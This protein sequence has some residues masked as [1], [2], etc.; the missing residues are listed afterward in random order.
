MKVSRLFT[1]PGESVCGRFEYNLKTSVLRNTDGSKVFE[2][3]EVEVPRHWSQ[4]AA[5]ILAQ[6]YFRKA[7]VPQRDVSGEF[8]RDESGNVVMGSENSVKQVVHRLAG[9]WREWGEKHGYFDTPEDGESFYDEMVY[10]LLAQMG[11]PNSPQWFNTGLNYAYGITGPAQGHYHVDPATKKVCESEDAYSR[12]QAHACFI[13]S[14]SD[15]LVNEGGIF[16][17]AIREARV[18]KFGSGSGTNYSNLRSSGEK[19]SGG[20]SSS[21]LMS[22]LKIFDSSAGAIKSGGTTRR[23]A[24]MV[25]IDIDHPD[26][27]QFIE[28]KAREEDKVASLV[29]GSRICSRFLQAIVSEALENGADRNKNPKLQR[30]IENAL[31]RAVPMNYIIRVLALVE[32]GF[33]SLDF[34]EYDTNYESE[35]YQTVGGQNSNNTVRVTN[36]FMKAVENDD[37]WTLKERTTG[38][39]ARA[40]NARDLWQKILMSAWK[41]ADPGLQ[42]DTTINEW[43][44][45]PNSGR[46]NA[47]NPC[48][49]YMF[50]DD[51]ACNLASLNL[52]H[53]LDEESGT[54]KVDEIRHASALWTIALE[55]SVLM[56]HFPSK[57]IARLSYEFR[58]LG[59]GFANLGTVLMVLGIPYDSPKALAL[60]GSIS[61]LITGQAYVTSAELARDLGPFDGYAAN[62]KEMLRVIRNH[63]RAA[64]N[65]S[66]DEY[67][68][69]SVKPRGIDS[70]YCSNELFS[71]VGKVWDEA[72]QKGKKHGFRNAQVSVIAP[73]G[74]IG[75]VMDCDT[76]G[77]EPEFAIV[78]FKKLAGGGYFKIVNQ[79]VHKALGRVGYTPEQIEEIE[80]YCKGSGTL[81]GCPSINRQWLIT[82]GF[83][84]ERIEVLEEQLEAVFDIRFAFNKWILGEDFCESLGFTEAQLNDPDF[85]MLEALGATEEDAEAANDY[86]CGTMTIEGAPHLKLEHLPIFDCASRC[87][88]KGQRFIN[89]MAHV[90]MMSGVQP[91]VSGAISKTVNMPST[92]TVNEISEVYLSGWHHMVKAITVYR[93]GSKLSQPLNISS[94]QDLDEVVMLGN[95]DDLDETK[96]PREVQE[97]II[98]RV[99]HRSER[100]MLPKRRKGYIREAYVGGHKV[101]L[102]TGEY[103][104]GS[105]GEVFIDMYKEGAS[106]K[107]LLNCFAVLASKALQYGMPLEELVESFTFT[108]FEPAGAVQGH[109]AIK[110][111]TSILDYVFRSIG[112]DYLGR[113][114]FVHVKAVDEVAQ[115]GV[116]G[117]E[118]QK[119]Q[120][121]PAEVKPVMAV[122]HAQSEYSHTLKNQIVQAKVQG[123]T[124]EQCENCGSMRVK[125]NGTCKVCED[126]GMTTGCS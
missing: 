73:T 28:W 96:G 1:R 43:H 30:L 115:N 122:H 64:H 75:L 11:A 124:G 65:K 58:T 47:S 27:E 16:D 93:D 44:T 86:I 104:D 61:A 120:E 70:E 72:L 106:F 57:D 101:F 25:I 53:F 109:N 95:E 105:L 52:I 29:V 66:E 59:L 40:V 89:H 31:Q 24:K 41:C 118:K 42:F 33:T 119:T 21:G 51:T 13:Q 5:D 22:F 82:R 38:K 6:K 56:A 103:E 87:G 68:G 97:R 81:A 100:R 117:K 39:G 114:D 99:Y 107:G 17:L 78:K 102:R 14:V 79:S 121:K 23:A 12:P 37:I 112:Y 80:L 49:E 54:I 91:F 108:R 32:Q 50:L 15:D 62:S 63:Q 110:N 71:V 67:E 8:L 10:M 9:C 85:N 60:A 76:T 46:I 111:S 7:G 34:D 74:T 26:V 77:I 20:G 35:A 48:S 3:N 116:A 19:L 2:M 18:F 36:E 4:M 98:E 88:R 55:I 92:A 90:R 113:K 84:D 123:Y 69:L 94:Y 125:Q 45:C 83:T 126:C